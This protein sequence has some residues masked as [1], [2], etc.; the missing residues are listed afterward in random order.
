MIWKVVK[1]S[2]GIYKITNLITLNSYIGQSKN[3]EERMR[4]H[5][6]TSQNPN[7]VD[8]DSPLH[9][10]LRK[11][12]DKDFSYEIVELCEESKLNEREQYWIQHYDSFYHGYNQTLGG[13]GCKNNGKPVLLYDIE[14]KFIKEIKNAQ[15]L[16][17]ELSLSIN[18]VRQV[19]YKNSKTLK[20]QYLVKY[21]NSQEEIIPFKTR[22]GGKRKVTQFSLD[23]TFIKTYNSITEASRILK[24]D[25]SAITKCCKGKAKTCGG[26]KWRYE[27]D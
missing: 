20:G 10:A 17:D 24:I 21:K 6:Y 16:A 26:F 13:Q 7:Y 3:I 25:T 2:C 15:A 5:K 23:G 8:Y 27:D 19:L 12:K 1:M 14:G 11:Y 22:Q 4:M 18:T 9:R